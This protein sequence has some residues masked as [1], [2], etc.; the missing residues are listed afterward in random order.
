MYA[1]FLETKA[2]P[3]LCSFT[4]WYQSEMCVVWCAVKVLVKKWRKSMSEKQSV[5]LFS[6]HLRN[7]H[8]KKKR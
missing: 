8:A 7:M 6:E 1:S 2:Q 5:D 3:G 4:T